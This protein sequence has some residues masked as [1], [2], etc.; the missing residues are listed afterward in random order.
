MST[1]R[2]AISHSD[3]PRGRRFEKLACPGVSMISSPGKRN[4]SLYFPAHRPDLLRDPAGLPT[5]TFVCRIL[6]S[7]F[8]F[9]VSTQMGNRSCL[10]IAASAASRRCVV[11]SARAG[12][13]SSGPWALAGAADSGAAGAG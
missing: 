4:S 12:G 9:P 2:I 6:S 13:G 10:S 1:T 3:D 11:V 8:V 5:C 7:S